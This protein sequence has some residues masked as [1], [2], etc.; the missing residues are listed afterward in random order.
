MN[1]PLAAGVA[2]VEPAFRDI[3]RAEGV[4]KYFGAVHALNN[5]NLAIGKNE[6]VCLFGDN[7]AG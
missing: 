6:I 1:Q 2:A 5:I 4:H 3:V 7:G